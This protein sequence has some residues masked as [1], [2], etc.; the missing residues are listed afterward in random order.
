MGNPGADLGEFLGIFQEI[1]NL[2]QFFLFLVRPGNIRKGDLFPVRHA[3]NGAGLAEII[4]G[5]IVVGPAHH[6]APDKQQHQPHNQQGQDQ[7]IGGHALSGSEMKGFQHAGIVLLH[8]QVV[9]FRAE[10]VGIRQRR[11]D[12]GLPGVGLVQVHGDH[13]V[14]HHKGLDLLVLEQLQHFGIGYLILTLGEQPADPGK[15]RHQQHQI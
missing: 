4:Q 14:I 9:H 6:K 11:R 13:I 5:V 8:K 12:R 1:H 3:Q 15:D 7:V 10:S 2:L